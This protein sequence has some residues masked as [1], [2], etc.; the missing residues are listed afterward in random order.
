MTDL[1]KSSPNIAEVDKAVDLG[2]QFL[3]YNER[4]PPFNDLAFRQALSAAIDRDEMANDAWGGAA[5]PANSL[6]LAGAEVLARSTASRRR[7]RRRHYRGAK[8]MLKDAGYVLVDGKLHYPA[9][10]KES[11]PAYERS[12]PT[13]ARHARTAGP[14]VPGSVGGRQPDLSCCSG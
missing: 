14:P 10:V 13:V 9:G 5:V 7:S 3:A 6:D 12:C 8:K 1:A 11:T 2:I 4:R